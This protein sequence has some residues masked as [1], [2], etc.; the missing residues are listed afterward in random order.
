MNSKTIVRR[1]LPLI[2]ALAII[3]LVAILWTVFKKP[4]KVPAI[5][6]PDEAFL[7]VGDVKITNG[8]VYKDLKYSY[9]LDTL[10]EMIDRDLLKETKNKDGVSYYDAV[11]DA[12]IEAEIEKAMFPNGRTG[13]DEKDNKTIAKWQRTK[14]LDEGL[15]SEEEIKAYY[16]LKLAKRAY[17]YDQLVLEDEQ[18]T[19]DEEKKVKKSDVSTYYQNNYKP[20]YWT[21]LIKYSTLTEATDA[22]AQLGIIAKDVKVSSDPDTFVKKWV[23]GGSGIELTHEEIKKA[24]IDLYNNAHSYEAPGYPNNDDPTKNLIL[25]SNQYTIENG[26]ITFN[27]TKDAENDEFNGKNLFYFPTSRLDAVSTSLTSAIKGL[28]DAPTE[29]NQN[30]LEKAYFISPRSVGTD[31]YFA[32][33]I[34]TEEPTELFDSGEVVNQD[35]YNEIRLKVLDSLVT[36]DYIAK[37]MVALRKG[38]EKNSKLVIFDEKLESSYISSYDSEFKATKKA[39]IVNVAQVGDKVYTADD[40]FKALANKYGVNNIF[41]RYLREKLMLDPNY[42]TIYDVNNKKILDEKQWKEIKEEIDGLKRSFANGSFG[43]DASYGW[44]NF[45]RDYNNIENEQALYMEF[46]Y[47]RVY[48]KFTKELTQTDEAKW[49]D[50]YLPNMQKKYNEYLSAT[51]IHLLIYKLDAEGNTI[52]PENWSDY[53]KQ[54]AKDLYDEILDAIKKERPSRIQNYLES[55]IISLY[56]NTPRFVADKKQEVNEQ[57]VGSDL[58]DWL[59]L[60]TTSYKYSAYKTAGL[61]IKFESLTTTAGVMVK[62]FEDAVRQI[63]NEAANTQF[64]SNTVIYDKTYKDYLVTEFGY[65]VYVN[66]TTTNRPNI[67]K[68]TNGVEETIVYQLPSYNDILVYEERPIEAEKDRELTDVEKNQISTY[69]SEIKSEIT[70]TYYRTLKVSEMFKADIDNFVFGN[71]ELKGVFEQFLDKKIEDSYDN[72]TYVTKK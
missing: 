67:V 29:Q 44:E 10:I 17:A 33:R 39:S 14:Y 71:A 25:G 21:I 48:E 4:K 50:I 6:N 15:K 57:P 2:I 9:G 64:G 24:H 47:D 62:P 66:L 13:D 26:V 38:T 63:W 68:T 30:K 34:T 40:L 20:A 8:S 16:R 32:Y 23:W 31:Y 55:T 37:K 51:G 58:I 72:L 35:L 52:N 56:N 27:T 22:L 19:K 65:H 36:D 43:V 3:I 1:I 5:S 59:E 28:S 69:F 70:G 45:L 49:N 11:T 61:L 54:L 53:D 60:D 18:A 41:S 12:A 42:N 7:S 46:V